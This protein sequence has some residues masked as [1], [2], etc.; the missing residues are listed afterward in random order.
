MCS[1]A[2]P[3]IEFAVEGEVVSGDVELCFGD[4]VTLD[5][6]ATDGGVANGTTTG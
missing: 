1:F 2:I 6:S 5:V 3:V 4:F